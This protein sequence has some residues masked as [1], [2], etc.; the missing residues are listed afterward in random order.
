M[1]A[2]R[3]TYLSGGDLK[4]ARFYARSS[5]IYDDVLWDLCYM[6]ICR[7]RPAENVIKLLLCVSRPARWREIQCADTVI[8]WCISGSVGRFF[9]PFYP[10]DIRGRDKRIRSPFWHEKLLVFPEEIREIKTKFKRYRNKMIVLK[11]EQLF[12]ERY[13]VAL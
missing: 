6:Y 12:V 7:E 2:L 13:Q 11:E 4:I 3:W 5:E 8:G 1:G 9:Q 10:S